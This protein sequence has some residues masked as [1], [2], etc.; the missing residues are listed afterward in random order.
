MHVHAYTSS[1]PFT[2]KGMAIWPCRFYEN[3]IFSNSVSRYHFKKY[4]SVPIKN[5]YQQFFGFFFA[6]WMVCDMHRNVYLFFGAYKWP[7]MTEVNSKTCILLLL[8]SSES[9]VILEWFL[10]PGIGQLLSR[11]VPKISFMTHKNDLNG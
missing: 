8:T 11:K 5:I 4:I 6:F 3:Q 9:P 10:T 2:S 7:V 1:I